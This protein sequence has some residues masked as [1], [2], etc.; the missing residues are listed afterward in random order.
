MINNSILLLKKE[1]KLQITIGNKKKISTSLSATIGQAFVSLCSAILYA[2]L[3]FKFGA[4]GTNANFFIYLSFTTL[5]PSIFL[6]WFQH[7]PQLNIA[8]SLVHS[9][10]KEIFQKYNL[11]ALFSAFCGTLIFFISSR[12]V[13]TLEVG[14]FISIFIGTYLTVLLLVLQNYM[15]F[16]GRQFRANSINFI[17]TCVVIAGVWLGNSEVFIAYHLSGLIIAFAHLL[18]WT[19]TDRKYIWK[20]AN[21][22]E[23]PSAESELLGD[24]KWRDVVLINNHSIQILGNIALRVIVANQGPIIFELYF[25][26]ERIA[27]MLYSTIAWAPINAIMVMQK[28]KFNLQ[29]A[30]LLFNKLIKFSLILIVCGLLTAFAQDLFT[31]ESLINFNELEEARLIL[32]WTSLLTL[33]FA[34]ALFNTVLTSILFM[35]MQLA[36]NLLISYLQIISV[37]SLYLITNLSTAIKMQIMIVGTAAFI[38]AIM[39]VNGNKDYLMSLLRSQKRKENFDSKVVILYFLCLLLALFVNIVK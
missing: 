11:L 32:S 34:I 4:S 3:Y 21:D 27:N 18:Y 12:F 10:R 9:S 6:Y 14:T 16:K 25:F 19:L 31:I 39:I 35:R 17:P 5:I 37:T 28:M 33:Y 1:G 13:E 20:N 8:F 22:L 38:R 30:F 7:N 15:I 29:D 2:S 36:K 24:K 23:V 26:A